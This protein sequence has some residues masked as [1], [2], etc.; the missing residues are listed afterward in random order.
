MRTSEYL[1]QQELMRCVVD[2]GPIA[3]QHLAMLERQKWAQATAERHAAW[4]ANPPAW[5]ATLE[6][7]TTPN[8]IGTRLSHWLGARLISA[9][10]RLEGSAT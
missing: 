1:T 5:A 7:S 6:G 2:S 9:G 3:G 8:G 4:K 10:H